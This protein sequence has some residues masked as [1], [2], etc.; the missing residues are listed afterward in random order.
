MR[1]KQQKHESNYKTLDGATLPLPPTCLAGGDADCSEE[2]LGA[3]L[4][5][6]DVSQARLP[7]PRLT[8]VVMASI[9]H[10]PLKTASCLPVTQTLTGN[11]GDHGD[12]MCAQRTA[13]LTMESLHHSRSNHCK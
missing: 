6:P 12:V 7:P 1:V 11:H 5:A 13:W 9:C 10:M 8:P 2:P 4:R 3:G